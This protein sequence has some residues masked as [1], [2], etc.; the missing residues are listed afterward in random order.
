M[1]WAQS[2]SLRHADDSQL[3]YYPALCSLLVQPGCTGTHPT[4]LLRCEHFREPPSASG[5]QVEETPKIDAWGP[6]PSL[7]Q[8]LR[9]L[10]PPGGWTPRPCRRLCFVN[11]THAHRPLRVPE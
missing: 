8:A 5:S 2:R 7:E 3:P 9:G 1:A 6:L 4:R 11:M 10:G